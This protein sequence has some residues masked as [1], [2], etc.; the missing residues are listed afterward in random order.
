MNRTFLMYIIF[1]FACAIITNILNDLIELYVFKRKLKIYNILFPGFKVVIP[2]KLKEL[3]KFKNNIKDNASFWAIFRFIH[4][5]TN[6]PM[7]YGEAIERKNDDT[8]T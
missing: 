3:R 6:M 2:N 5:I 8:Q 1:C 4:P 7:K